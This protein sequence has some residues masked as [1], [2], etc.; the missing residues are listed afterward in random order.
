MR[1]ACYTYDSIC[2]LDQSGRGTPPKPS[3]AAGCRADSSMQ[4]GQGKSV[5]Y[6]GACHLSNGILILGDMFVLLPSL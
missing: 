6:G 2:F 1:M 4:D 3:K 5:V